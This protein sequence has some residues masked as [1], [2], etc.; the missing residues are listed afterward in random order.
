MAFQLSQNEPARSLD[1][2]R[3]VSDPATREAAL[4][5]VARTWLS[6]DA[7]SA[8]TWLAGTTDLSAESRRVILRQFDE[9]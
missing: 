3:R 1:Y 2:A 5:N 4:T 9:R 6:R 7:A 8:R